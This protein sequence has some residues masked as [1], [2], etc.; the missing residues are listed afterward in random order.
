M[1]CSVV[2]LAVCSLHNANNARLIYRR[3]ARLSLPPSVPVL[4]LRRGRRPGIKKEERRASFA[5]RE[6]N[7]KCGK[8]EGRKKDGVWVLLQP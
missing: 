8:E 3:A 7:A 5:V 6:Q 1:Q 2:V 4:R